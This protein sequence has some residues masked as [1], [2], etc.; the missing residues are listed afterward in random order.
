MTDPVLIDGTEYLAIQVV[1]TT[2][3]TT[4]PEHRV[5]DQ[6]AV[7]DHIIHEPV[8][9]N[10]TIALLRSEYSRLVA[11][12]DAQE[13]VT[14]TTRTGHH[15]NMALLDVE[16]SDE[17]SENVIQTS[18]T[19]K[20]IRTTSTV[21]RTLHLPPGGEVETSGPSPA[22]GS[23]STGS[24]DVSSAPAADDSGSWIAGIGAFLAGVFGA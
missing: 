24:A 1:N 18:L 13:L 17:S 4:V 7:G 19:F 11:M 3:P 8:T 12:R 9:L 21:T 16:I 22:T 14:V 15:D 23:E 6:Y 2:L 20:Q 5:E 10:I